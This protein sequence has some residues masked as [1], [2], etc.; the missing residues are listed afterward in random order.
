MRAFTRITAAAVFGAGADCVDVQ[1]SISG[2]PEGE[3]VFRIVGLPD[4]AMREGRER[5]RNAVRHG[6]W[7]WPQRHVTVNL[8]PA[9][10]RFAGIVRHTDAEREYAYDRAASI[11]RLDKALDAAATRGWVVVDMRRAWSRVFPA[12]E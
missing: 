4:S 5:I 10:A 2:Q 3:P 8:A 6:G 1:V 12:T 11:G 7:S 9:G